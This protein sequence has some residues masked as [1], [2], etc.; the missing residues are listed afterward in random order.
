MSPT[1]R[2][3]AL[4]PSDLVCPV[5]HCVPSTHFLAHTG[6]ASFYHMAKRSCRVNTWT[7]SLTPKLE[8]FLL[9]SALRPELGLV[10]R[11]LAGSRAGFC[12]GSGRAIVQVLSSLPDSVYPFV[13]SWHSLSHRDLAGEN[14]NRSLSVQQGE[15]L[16]FLFFFS[17]LDSAGASRG[18]LVRD[19]PWC[20]LI[21]TLSITCHHENHQ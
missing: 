7:Q 1:T 6:I 16:A 15:E 4:W 21:K 10:G 8:P 20:L 3:W 13:S 12:S 9:P 11:D 19:V 5:H 17:V 14:R 18:P 2:T